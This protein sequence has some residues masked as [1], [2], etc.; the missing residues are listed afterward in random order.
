M[1]VGLVDVMDLCVHLVKYGVFLRCKDVQMFSEGFFDTNV[2][3]VAGLHASD[4]VLP[5]QL[6]STL[7]EVAE[8]LFRVATHRAVAVKSL[9]DA[10]S[11][12]IAVLTQT[13]LL[14]FLSDH[15]SV[16]EPHPE[17]LLGALAPKKL[18]TM[19]QSE[20]TLH[21]FEKIQALGVSAIA[22]V[23]EQGRL[24]NSVSASNVR[25]LTPKNA[26]WLLL[27]VSEWL[28]KMNIHQANSARTDTT[29]KDAILT[30]RDNHL[31]RL[32]IVDENQ[33]LISVLTVGDV[34]RRFW[35]NALLDA[36]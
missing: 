11:P 31:H 8:G 27:P 5:F 36:K 29:F 20:P 35:D 12:I 18:L 10:N 17:T 32:W 25:L 26:E 22:V 14:S 15:I 13:K 23:D 21:A 7:G 30:V 6:D 19:Q 28:Q 4:R 34:L 3:V 9:T 16:F 33:K 1:D 24:V 2:T